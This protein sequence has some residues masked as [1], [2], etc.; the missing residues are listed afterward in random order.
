MLVCIIYTSA[1]SAMYIGTAVKMTP[2][3]IP[4]N[5][6]ATYSDTRLGITPIM[7]H[8]IADSTMLNSIVCLRPKR[9]S[10]IPASI[11][12]MAAPNVTSEPTQEDWS[13]V[14]FMPVSPLSSFT[15]VG[16]DH[17]SAQPAASA[18]MFTANAK[19]NITILN[20]W[21]TVVI[22]FDCK[23]IKH[24]P[25]CLSFVMWTHRVMRVGHI[26]FRFF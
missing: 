9:S 22:Y 8:E 25:K 5:N 18:P 16:E 4:A 2:T 10:R 6:R 21:Y 14:I 12:P 7:I 17:V 19:H 15:R 1:I 20:M 26:F 24:I 11:G 23:F 13:L 3:A